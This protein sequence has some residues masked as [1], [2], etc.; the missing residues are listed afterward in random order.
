MN[1]QDYPS[2]QTNIVKITVKIKIKGI[3]TCSKMLY[4]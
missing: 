3:F 2:N 4:I 1:E